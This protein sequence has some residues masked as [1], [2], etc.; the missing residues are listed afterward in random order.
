[1]AENEKTTKQEY[2]F[3]APSAAPAVASATVSDTDSSF[4]PAKFGVPDESKQE[5]DSDASEN[6]LRFGRLQYAIGLFWQP[7]QDV[8]DPIPE[9]REIMESEPSYNLYA[10]HYG[11]APQY[12]IGSTQK[13]HKAGLLVGA[14]ALQDSLSERSSFIAVFKIPAG[15][16][17][18]AAR[19]DLILPEEDVLYL[20]EQEAKD[21]YMAMLAV[22]DWGYK[23][24]PSEWG[25][26]DTEEMDLEK[27]LK[28]GQQVRL[29]SLGA[30]RG[31]KILTV[32]ALLTVALI[33]GGVYVLYTFFNREK[34]APT[35]IEPIAPL[36]TIQ[37]QEPQREEEKPWEKLV[38]VPAL[39]SRCWSDAYQMKTMT[40]PGWGLN[41]I[42]CTP[43]GI[44]TGWNKRWTRAGRVAWVESAIRDQYKFK[45]EEQINETGTAATI[46]FKF[47]DLP[48]TASTPTLS[49][50][51][52]RRE[53]T[54]ISQALSLPISMSVGQITVEMPKPPTE[55]GKPNPSQDYVKVYKYLSFSFTSSMDPPA[56]ESFFDKFN[57]LEVTKIEYNPNSK[58]ALTNNWKYEGRIYANEK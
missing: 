13:G 36:V 47:D 5:K 23:I 55:D 20:T 52:I 14:I 35:P 4:Q 1:M 43:T 16:W 31:L 9:I 19:N 33:G 41:Q 27:L 49:L 38:S 48:I 57:G 46:A 18:V 10:T 51:K 17:F 28:E 53:L 26:D 39:L 22:P 58:S 45:G 42:T 24:A 11:R 40:V 34:S 8:D 44:Q 54:D 3:A 50:A 25:F 32:I 29:L 21:A 2:H 15:W 30:M 12:G 7:L 56:W 37:A 6:I